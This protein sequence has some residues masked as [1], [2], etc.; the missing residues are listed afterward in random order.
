MEESIQPDLMETEVVSG[1]LS[2]VYEVVISE[3]P[4]GSLPAPN[5][6]AQPTNSLMVVEVMSE[7]L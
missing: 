2:T 4:E 7:L 1:N 3:E 6:P 5:E